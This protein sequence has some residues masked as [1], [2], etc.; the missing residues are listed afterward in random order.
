MEPRFANLS[1][2]QV[3]FLRDYCPKDKTYTSTLEM[4][5]IIS[6]F[7]LDEEGVSVEDMQA[8]RNSIVRFYTHLHRGV[9]INGDEERLDRIA[10]ALMSVTSVF[11]NAMYHKSLEKVRENYTKN[12]VN[13]SI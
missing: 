11:D 13:Y 10:L 4:K 8:M 6:K 1:Q 2:N 7:G 5:N 12:Y 3:D 9:L